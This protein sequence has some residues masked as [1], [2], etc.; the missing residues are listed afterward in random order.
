MELEE[1]KKQGEAPEFLTEIG[2]KTLLGGYLLPNETPKG[3]WTRVARTAANI[4]KKPELEEKFFN[5]LWNG[6]VGLATPVASNLGANRGLPISCYSISPMDSTSSILQKGHELA[7]LTKNGGGVGIYMGDLRPAGS[8]IS[9]GGTSE[10][11]IP[12]AKIYD[13]IAVG[14]SQGCYDD[15]T[16]ILTESGWILFQDLK[17]FPDLKVMQ[18]DV[19]GNSSFTNYTD[20]IEYGVDEDLYFI[21]NKTN[22]VN[23]LLTGNHRVAV[24]KRKRISNKRDKDGKFLCHKKE[25]T[26]FLDITFAENLKLHRDNRIWVASRRHEGSLKSLSDLDQFKIA[27]Q[28]DGST[29]ALSSGTLSEHKPYVFRFTKERKINRFENLLEKLKFKYTKTVYENDAVSFYVC[30]P[31]KIELDKQLSNMFNISQ[32]SKDFAGEFIKEVSHWD[33]HVPSAESVHYSCV[34]E[35]NVDFL[36]SVSFI[37]GLMSHKTVQRN[38]PGNRVD[39]YC[40]YISNR[41]SVGGE[42][43]YI[44]S[45][46]YRGNV[47]C[48]TV[49]DGLLVIRRQGTVSICGNSVRRGAA[50]IYLPVDHGD[51]KAFLRMRRPEGDPNRQCLNLHHAV[52]IPDSFMHK[53]ESGDEAS[54]EL[55]KEI[56]KSRLETG[57]PYIF[58][59]DNVN[60]QNPE[61]YTKNNLKISTSNICSEILLYTDPDHT[62]VCCLSS[63]NL[64]KWHEWKDTDTVELSVYL[65]DAVLTEFIEKAQKL[66]GF[67]AAVRSAIK[68]R[69][70]G[71]G[72]MGWHTLLQQERAGMSSF[73]A[74]I[75]N[76]A[77]FKNINENAIKASK[78]LAEELGEPE[79]CKGTGLRSTHL[80]A[81]APTASNSLIT[82]NISAGIEPINANA[83]VKKT[84]KG[85]FIE[86]NPLL[87]KRLQELGKDTEEVWNAI[88][89]D[90][91][92][93][94][95]LDFLSDDD[96]DVFKTA[97]EIDQLT[98]IDLA[99]D[100]QP[101]ICQ[102]Q[103]LNLFFSKDVDPQYFHEVHW[104]A[105]LKKVKTLYYVRSSSVLRA[106]LSSRGECVACEG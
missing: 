37:A 14:I 7:M 56:Y 6:W 86:F 67:E 2:Y 98:L 91:G 72:V 58:Y 47:Y 89:K 9:A 55:L 68:G 8:K 80:I 93:V 78:K 13:S 29:D 39:L 82:G 106:D 62:F 64:A 57:E 84:A 71:L 105:W 32:F 45:Q 70:L 5:M 15:Q 97:F 20:Y 75:L 104:T 77:I 44:A 1:L 85:T 43:L 63:L 21:N 53:V 35:S 52:C 3:M 33:G 100:R 23:L 101:F 103:S 30:V 27:Y 4:L 38:R 42:E 17:H 36:Q 31:K 25:L 24:E 90:E 60:S 40:I 18:V 51:I 46:H 102:A 76:K 61:A 48:V 69:A 49:P 16:E 74:K 83:Y 28:A 87:K 79:W 26:G 34:I 10:G 99:A 65:L 22:S 81:I 50:A 92:S 19:R 88:V 94:R 12:F 95:G 66:Q 96:K 59:S 73:R 11:M 41:D 54:Q